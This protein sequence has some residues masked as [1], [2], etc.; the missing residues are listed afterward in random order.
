MSIVRISKGAFPAE[1]Y[2]QVKQALDESQASL[3]PAIKALHGC[4]AYYAGI[5]PMTNTM[6]NVSV[7]ETMEDA[8]QMEGLAPM[9][10]LAGKFI[11]ELQVEFE[12]PI[13]NY[14][15]LWQV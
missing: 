7:W 2:E 9:Q 11:G 8:K 13:A 5:D 1:M 4:M 12:R 14:E 6:I 10:A 3:V 15:T